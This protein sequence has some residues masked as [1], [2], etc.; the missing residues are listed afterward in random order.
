MIL[1]FSLLTRIWETNHCQKETVPSG[2]AKRLSCI[3]DLHFYKHTS[4]IND[5]VTCTKAKT[6]LSEND[7]YNL[8]ILNEELHEE[9]RDDKEQQQDIK[10]LKSRI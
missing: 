4:S 8:S 10:L 9:D 3:Q 1:H 7:P 2:G 5:L 6:K